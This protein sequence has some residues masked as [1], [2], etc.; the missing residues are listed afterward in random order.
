[1]ELNQPGTRNPA[2]TFR[3][4]S[5]RLN[6]SAFRWWEFLD[7]NCGYRADRHSDN[8][9]EIFKQIPCYRST[10]TGLSRNQIE[11]PSIA[12]RNHHKNPMISTRFGFNEQKAALSSQNA[13]EYRWSRQTTT[14]TATTTVTTAT[15]ATK[16]AAAAV[17]INEK[18]Q[19]LRMIDGHLS[20]SIILN[21][22][23][24]N[25]KT[26]ILNWKKKSSS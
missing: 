4:E 26:S 2:G 23:P 19:S 17:A 10:S 5:F 16:T 7:G 14:T 22:W 24:C 3:A 6:N 25:W 11:A 8:W 13:M 9:I 21:W 1:M 20:S 15:A 18:N 12:G